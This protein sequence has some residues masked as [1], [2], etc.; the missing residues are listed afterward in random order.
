MIVNGKEYPFWSQFVEKSDE[1]VGRVLEDFDIGVAGR[2]KVTGITLRPNG[3]DSAYF[4]IEGEDFSCG[5]DVRVGGVIGGEEGYI[6][7][8]GYAGHEFRVKNA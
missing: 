2:T 5:F 3:K 4:T 1:F 6:T 7:F 8:H